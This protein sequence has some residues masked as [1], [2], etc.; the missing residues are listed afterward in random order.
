MRGKV[1]TTGTQAYRI[2][3]IEEAAPIVSIQ[4][5]NMECHMPIFKAHVV[6][7]MRSATYCSKCA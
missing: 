7:L 2:Q 3:A 6:C 1:L 5:Y 4:C